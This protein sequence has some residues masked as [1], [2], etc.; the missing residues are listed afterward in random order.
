MRITNK[1]SLRHNDLICE[2]HFEPEQILTNWEHIIGGKVVSLKREKPKLKSDAVP[3]RNLHVE[4]PAPYS[5]EQKLTRTRNARSDNKKRKTKERNGGKGVDIDHD[6]EMADSSAIAEAE[7]NTLPVE[8]ERSGKTDAANAE[9]R[10][11]MFESLHDDIYEVILPSTLWGI[12]RD[13]DHE[14]IA[15]SMFDAQRMS[16]TKTVFIDKTLRVQT[17][18]NGS[19]FLDES[20]EE[21]NTE[22]VTRILTEIDEHN[23]AEK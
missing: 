20:F 6:I 4:C 23:P 3:L 17:H 16:H 14:F 9:E 7:L 12:H 1:R 11:K 21:L 13:P 10:L 15:F 18:V 22:I 2:R 5:A 8:E 19:I